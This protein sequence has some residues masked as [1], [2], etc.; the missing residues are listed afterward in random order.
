MRIRTG[1]F[2]DGQYQAPHGYND[3]DALSVEGCTNVILDHISTSWS[4]DECMSVVGDSNDITVQWCIMAEPLTMNGHAEASLLRPA[5]KSRLTHHHNLYSDVVTRVTRFGNYNDN[6]V[7]R[8]NWYNN[9]VFN[10]GSECTYSNSKFGLWNYLLRKG[11]ETGSIDAE[12]VE[13]NM[14]DNYFVAGPGTSWDKAYLANN[15]DNHKLWFA[16]NFMDSDRQQNEHDGVAVSWEVVAGDHS[17][18]TEAFTIAAPY[19]WE[20]AEDAYQK[21]LSH[22]G[23]FFCS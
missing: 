17:Q 10:N 5:M 2:A 11:S 9:V 6:A 1:H 23:D 13:L 15:A 8:F 7:T 12:S 20:S 4:K 14:M 16:G 21:V 22:A 18:M 3:L 19:I